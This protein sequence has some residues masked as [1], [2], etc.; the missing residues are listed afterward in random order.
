[1]R[2]LILF[3]LIIVSLTCLAQE[4]FL[5]KSGTKATY[6]IQIP[7]SFK[8]YTTTIGA[9]IDLIFGDITGA[10]II[11]VVRNISSDYTGDLLDEMASAT[12]EELK[13]ELEAN[14]V[15]NVNIL[16]K[17]L[18]NINGRKTFY[19]YYTA[20]ANGESQYYHS[21]VQVIK[22]KLIAL[23]QSCVNSKKS[24]YMPYFFRTLNSL[25][26]R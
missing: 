10:S 19:Q 2:L 20:N 13:N 5:L 24:N 22:N 11:T 15:E 17:G 6:T 8:T 16:K 14:G 26:L 21:I 18:T 1:M 3:A 4:K 12:I 23:T 7:E 25:K 9:N